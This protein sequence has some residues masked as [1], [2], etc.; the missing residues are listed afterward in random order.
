MKKYC[1]VIFQIV[2][3]ETVKLD[4]LHRTLRN[5]LARGPK[6]HAMGLN[7]E[8]KYVFTVN[9]TE[10]ILLGDSSWVGSLVVVHELTFPAGYH[11][12]GQAIA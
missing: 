9:F 1:Y 6:Y 4:D 11:G 7:W 3:W 5:F 8:I 10:I 2:D 12:R